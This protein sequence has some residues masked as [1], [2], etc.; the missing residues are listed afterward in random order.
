MLFISQ[1]EGEEKQIEITKGSS[2]TFSSRS[3]T[4]LD[5]TCKSC[6]SPFCCYHK[7]SQTGKFVKNRTLSLIHGSDFLIHCAKPFLYVA[8]FPFQ[9][10]G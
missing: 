6:V 5:F 10:S 9:V 4:V 3:Y 8:D 2:F 7:M 1:F